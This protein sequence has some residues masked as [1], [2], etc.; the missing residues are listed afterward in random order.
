M[1]LEVRAVL[2]RRVGSLANGTR[3]AVVCWSEDCGDRVK[4]SPV[5]GQ[6]RPVWCSL[7]D[8]NVWTVEPSPDPDAVVSWPED[9]HVQAKRFAFGL[10]AMAIEA[11]QRLAAGTGRLP[12][13]PGP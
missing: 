13:R 3:V 7:A 11:R 4:V 6:R 1:T 8:L 2:R 9:E 10:S 5:V 12:R